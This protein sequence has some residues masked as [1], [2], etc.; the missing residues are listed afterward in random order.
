MVTFWAYENWRAHGHTVTVHR[1]DCPYCK[2]GRGL[3]GGTRSDNGKWREL[4][5]FKTSI[6]ALDSARRTL[7]VAA[8]KLCGLEARLL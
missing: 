4:G 5:E 3:A 8:M 6:D 1:A 2:G 7:K